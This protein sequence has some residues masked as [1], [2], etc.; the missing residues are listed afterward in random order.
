MDCDN[1]LGSPRSRPIYEIVMGLPRFEY[2]HILSGLLPFF[3]FAKNKSQIR[4]V[5]CL[6]ENA[7]FGAHVDSSMIA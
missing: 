5:Q 1:A 6:I 2:R 7:I 4:L 3:S